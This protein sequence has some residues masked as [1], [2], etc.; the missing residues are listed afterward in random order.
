MHGG[1][2]THVVPPQHSLEL[3][4]ED[5]N[6]EINRQEALDMICQLERRMPK[7]QQ[8][9]APYVVQESPAVRP[10]NW[11]LPKWN[12]LALPTVPVEA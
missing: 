1:C 11:P 5:I 8:Q 6:S 4:V 9:P 2:T 7:K 3:E 10:S 12:L